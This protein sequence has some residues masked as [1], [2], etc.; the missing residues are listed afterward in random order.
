MN[1]SKK[2]KFVEFLTGKG[3]YIALALSLL[4]AGTAA[5]IAVDRT[6]DGITDMNLSDSSSSLSSSR[7][8]VEGDQSQWDFPS[9]EPADG[10]TS[11]VDKS[12]A[13]SQSSASSHSS[14]S[15]SAVSSEQ[16]D[17]SKPSETLTVQSK[18]P[19]MLPTAGQV[20]TQYSGGELVKSVTLNE[21]RT[22]DGIDFAGTIGDPVKAVADGTVK[23]IYEDDQWGNVVVISHVGDLESIYASL[24]KNVNV[25]VGEEVEIGQVIGSVSES[26][27]IEIG[28]QPHLHFAMKQNGEWVDPLEIMGKTAN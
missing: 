12:S 13:S 27:E 3:F 20:I 21:W 26:A 25:V 14:A 11:G 8:T 10:N 15:S 18:Q 22:H 24:G 19:F 28:L 23:E 1:H 5:W 16:D 2:S 9:L 6:L 7:I 17:I 4:G